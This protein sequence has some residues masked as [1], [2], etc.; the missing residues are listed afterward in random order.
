[1]IPNDLWAELQQIGREMAA[2]SRREREEAAA[3]AARKEPRP[4]ARY[5][6]V[7]GSTVDLAY[8]SHSGLLKATCAGCGAAEVI[9]TGG[10]VTDP[11]EKEDAR[12]DDVLPEARQWAQTHAET[13][14]AM[15][16]QP[17]TV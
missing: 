15:P 2:R 16:Y 7:G 5:L 14:R 10:L 6:T 17:A 11:P 4:I 8:V 12:V 3:A 1:M 9:D 13:C